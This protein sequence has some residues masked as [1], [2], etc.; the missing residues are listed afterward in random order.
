MLFIVLHRIPLLLCTQEMSVFPVTIRLISDP[1]GLDL[2]HAGV[3]RE[4]RLSKNYS[5]TMNNS[6]IILFAIHA[7]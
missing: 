1:D 7:C 3:L 4:C 2:V 5:Y 6:S